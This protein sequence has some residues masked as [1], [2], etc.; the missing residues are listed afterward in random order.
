MELSNSHFPGFLNS[1]LNK[2]I[3][4]YANVPYRIKN[5]RDIVANPKNTVTF[6]NS[7]HKSIENSV[8]KYGADAKLILESNGN[9]KLVS[10]TEK[11]LATLLAKLSNFIPEAGIWMNTPS[12]QNG[13]MPTMHL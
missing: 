12:V 7:L 6:D 9:V 11:L 8:E 3:F 10:L 13:T 5:Y 4:A 1:W 2:E